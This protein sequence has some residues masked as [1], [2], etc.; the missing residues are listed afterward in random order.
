MGVR[1]DW[2]GPWKGSGCYSYDASGA[3]RFHEDGS[4]VFDDD[5]G[6]NEFWKVFSGGD[7]IIY[8]INYGGDLLYYKDSARNGTPAWANAGIGQRIGGQWGD[9]LQVFSGGDGIIYAVA[10]PRGTI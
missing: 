2:S 5:L 9:F 3:A 8:A 4:H 10:P 1:W 6:W 7:G